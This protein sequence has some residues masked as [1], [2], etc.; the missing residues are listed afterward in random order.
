MMSEDMG[1][2]SNGNKDDS[3]SALRKAAGLFS[4]GII[5]SVLF[6]VSVY[7]FELYDRS[8][9]S[10][11]IVFLMFGIAF[12]LITYMLTIA[13]EKYE[14][15]I[16]TV[17][18]PRW[19]RI[20]STVRAW[21]IIFM[22]WFGVIW[23]KGIISTQTQLDLTFLD[24]LLG[25]FFIGLLLFLSIYTVAIYYPGSQ[26]LASSRKNEKEKKK[27]ADALTA[28]IPIVGFPIILSIYIVL[29]SLQIEL[30]P[31]WLNYIVFFGVYIGE[32]LL[33]VHIP[34]YISASEE[35]N[36]EINILKRKRLSIMKS[37]GKTKY[38]G[39]D[40]LL[41]RLALEAEIA[42]LDRR[43]EVIDSRKVHPYSLVIPLASF[44]MTI[45]F[46][47]IMIEIIKTIPIFG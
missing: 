23:G 9:L 28:L 39:Q 6:T 22:V 7:A 25:Y 29:F 3:K 30:E 24:L 27:I 4:G 13:T 11:S 43:I 37:L 8:K 41:K 20:V 38:N 12:L 16:L 44:L 21:I 19:K 35:K 42:R 47:T 15:K 10:L 26:Y 34:Y 45:F 31:Y 2:D 5:G 1:T 18:P 32:F 33:S 46:A 36:H 40:I 14:E 17:L